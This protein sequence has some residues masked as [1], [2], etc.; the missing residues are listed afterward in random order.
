MV[1]PAFGVDVPAVVPVGT[2]Q[3]FHRLWLVRLVGRADCPRSDDALQDRSPSPPAKVSVFVVTSGAPGM[4]QVQQVG[5]GL[6]VLV[7]GVAGLGLLAPADST[8][9]STRSTEPG[10]T[11]TKSG[12]ELNANFTGMS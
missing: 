10:D 3:P 12:T 7:L 8:L 4:Q 9:A 6:E 11:N 5:D 2:C 1:D